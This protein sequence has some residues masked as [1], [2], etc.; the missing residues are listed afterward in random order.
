MKQIK[1]TITID[2]EE[3]EYEP[4]ISELVNEIKS[5]NFDSDMSSAGVDVKSMVSVK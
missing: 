1:I 5:G 2:C 3:S 4:K